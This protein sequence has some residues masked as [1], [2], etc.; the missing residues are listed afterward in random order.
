MRGLATDAAGLYHARPGTGAVPSMLHIHPVPAFSDNYIWVLHDEAGNALAVDP[1]DAEPVIA[2]LQTHR[3]RLTGILITHHH[4]DHT[5]G[6]AALRGHFG[7]IEVH[8]PAPSPFAGISQ[9]ACPE[10]ELRLLGR[11][12]KVISVPGHTLDHIA[13]FIA[14]EEGQPPVLLCGD[15]LFAG[16]CGRVFEGDPGMMYASLQRLAALPDDTRV[17]CAHEYTLSNL[18]FAR[19]VEP[20]NEDL[21]QRQARDSATRDLDLPTVPS[22]LSLERG[23][24]PFLRCAEAAVRAAAT[25]HAGRELAGAAD[26]FAVIRAWKDGYR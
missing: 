9:A 25:Q 6:V 15:T 21:L 1:G 23:T 19:T 11:S 22:T 18:R 2:F 5:G 12:A 13:Y 10:T 16:G 3:L 17:C 14:A 20:S 26:V 24:N 7:D 8:G 4:L